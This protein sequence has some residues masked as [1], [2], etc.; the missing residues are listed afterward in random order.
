MQ[1]VDILAESATKRW[2][3]EVKDPGNPMAKRERT[4]KFL[5]ELAPGN[6][7]LRGLV[8]KCRDSWLYQWAKETN[9][10]EKVNHYF[11]LLTLPQSVGPGVHSSLQENLRHSLP[12]THQRW[13]RSLVTSIAVLD[14]E[15][16]N[17]IGMLGS[18]RRI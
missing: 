10:E 15:T 7:H 16:W 3:V 4:Q 18:V 13:K 5:D 2:F 14:I 17:K 9:F 6:K 1:A 11:V 12:V 8:Q